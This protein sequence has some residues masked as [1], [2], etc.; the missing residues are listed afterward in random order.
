MSITWLS[1]RESAAVV[2]SDFGISVAV[3]GIA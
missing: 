2:G 1:R 3:M